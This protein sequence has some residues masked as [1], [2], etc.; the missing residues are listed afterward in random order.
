MKP[1]AAR[2]PVTNGRLIAQKSKAA[3]AIVVSADAY[4][5]Y[6]GMLSHATVSECDVFIDWL[7][8]V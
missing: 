8:M 3:C 4:A 6:L 2:I 7:K 1:S 5:V